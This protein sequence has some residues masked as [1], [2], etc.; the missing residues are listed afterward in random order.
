MD[1][2]RLVPEA[3]L[4]APAASK[5]PPQGANPWLAGAMAGALEAT[6]FYPTVTKGLAMEMGKPFQYRA[7]YQGFSMALPINIALFA[8][9]NGSSSVTKRFFADMGERAPS[10]NVQNGCRA[11]VAGAAATAL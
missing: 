5:A 1:S 11:A 6:V 3:P 2:M 8:A 9:M 7:A 4:S 10:P